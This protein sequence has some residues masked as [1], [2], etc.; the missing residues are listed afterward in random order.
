MKRTLYFLLTFLLL[1]QIG[2]TSDTQ[3]EESDPATDSVQAPAI[4]RDSLPEASNTSAAAPARSPAR[5]LSQAEKERLMDEIGFQLEE[6][7]GREAELE[8]R[9]ASLKRKKSN[10][11]REMEI[12]G[13]EKELGQVK[14]ETSKLLARLQGI[15]AR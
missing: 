1:I 5:K 13:V 4:L 15:Q 3:Q 11:E 7:K 14:K 10:P 6:L 2:C 9:I 12:Q 8:G